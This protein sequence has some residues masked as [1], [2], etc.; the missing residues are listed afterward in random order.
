MLRDGVTP[1]NTENEVWCALD[2]AGSAGAA[3]FWIAYIPTWAASVIT[4][5]FGLSATVGAIKDI[6]QKLVEAGFAMNYQIIFMMLCWFT[7]W[8]FF[9]LGL[10]SYAGS[11]PDSLGWGE[12]Q[13]ESSFG[14]A[15]LSFLLVTVA[16]S[17]LAAKVWDLWEEERFLEAVGDFKNARGTRSAMYWILVIQFFMYLLISIEVVDF[18]A[19][20][21][22][23]ALY[24]LDTDNSNFLLMYCV[25]TFIT[26]LFDVMK[27]CGFPSFA[28]LSGGEGFVDVLYILVF[29]MKIAVLALIFVEVKKKGSAPPSSE[30]PA[31]EKS[32][33][34]DDTSDIAE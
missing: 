9:F 12:V 2:K 22:F 8:I 13:F 27:L 7:L 28:V 25:C 16:S 10:V 32:N 18:S 3:L 15:R 23:F 30:K 6:Q 1:Y 34:I 19:L 33:E 29:L 17:L 21:C 14:L 11:V 24:W 4:M 20:L 5:I 31:D 26:V